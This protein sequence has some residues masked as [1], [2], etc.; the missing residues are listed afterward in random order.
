MTPDAS[1]S[2][3]RARAATR[4]L[5]ARAH[6]RGENAMGAVGG[7]FVAVVVAVCYLAWSW[8][9]A[10]WDYMAMKEI[11]QTTVRDWTNHE[12]VEKAKARLEAELKRKDVSSDV[13]LQA[14]NFV[15]KKGAYELQ[16]AWT[17]YAYYPGTSYYKAFDGWVNATFSDTEGGFGPG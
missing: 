13:T 14:C 11:A 10:Y 5:R 12:N 17:T 6:R 1:W 7:L 16:C 4:T 3:R 15:D 9:P 8:F 2:P